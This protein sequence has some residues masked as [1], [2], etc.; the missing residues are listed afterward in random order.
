MPC[1]ADT[2]KVQKILQNR[3][4][5]IVRAIS[6]APVAFLVVQFQRKITEIIEVGLDPG[7]KYHFEII[8]LFYKVPT[9]KSIKIKKCAWDAPPNYVFF[10]ECLFYTIFFFWDFCVDEG[11]IRD[12]LFQTRDIEKP[13]RKGRNIYR[14]CDMGKYVDGFLWDS[15]IYCGRYTFLGS[16]NGLVYTDLQK[17]FFEEKSVEL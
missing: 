17:H 5:G 12:R 8:I 6:G 9:A 1:S 4:R 3:L 14:L 13:I 7:E 16:Q 10:R 15:I 2:S 11:R